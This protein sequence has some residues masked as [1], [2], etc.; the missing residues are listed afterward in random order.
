MIWQFDTLEALADHF[1][2]PAA[3]LKAQVARWNDMVAAGKD[4]EFDRAL[5][6]AIKLD[7]PPFYA[8]R[9]WP[10]VH[11]CMGGVGINKHAQVV[12]VL[13]N[14]I[15]G[16]YAAGEVTGGAH[17]ASRLGG[18]AIADGLV[19]GRIAADSAV[20]AQAAAI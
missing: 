10:K 6:L 9:V 3:E 2:M 14:P 7:K 12:D 11:Y 4:K 19:F 17:G 5:Q 18:C 8:C 1:K 15:A 16:L 20:A 13:G